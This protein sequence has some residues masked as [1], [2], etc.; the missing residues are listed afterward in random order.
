MPNWSEEIFVVS[1]IKNT[2][3]WIYVVNDLNGEQI[4]GTFY[5]EEL[6]KTNQQEFRIEK[7]IKRK[8]VNYMLNGEVI[9][10]HLIVGLIKKILCKNESIF[11]WATWT[12]W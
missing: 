11:S 3:P 12:I 8:R 10:I 6:Q 5:E 1:K 4:I 2:V 7:I 9:I